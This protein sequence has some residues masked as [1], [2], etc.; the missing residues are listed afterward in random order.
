MQTSLAWLRSSSLLR[1]SNGRAAR[2]GHGKNGHVLRAVSVSSKHGCASTN[3]NLLDSGY[4]RDVSLPESRELHGGCP[5]HM[6]FTAV[7]SIQD[8]L[9][10]PIAER[11]P[12]MACMR[13]PE[14]VWSLQ[15]SFWLFLWLCLGEPNLKSWYRPHTCSSR[16]IYRYI[17]SGYGSI[18][19]I[20]TIFEDFTTDVWV[21]QGYCKW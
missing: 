11:T 5:F 18:I 15:L 10:A 13:I 12:A 17:Q 21:H 9:G 14:F 7:T 19:P 3:S 4:A 6:P 2:D 8:V 1:R 20:T 16:N